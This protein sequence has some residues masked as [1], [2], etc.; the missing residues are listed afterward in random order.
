MRVENLITNILRGDLDR[1]NLLLKQLDGDYRSNPEIFNEKI[2]KILNERIDG[3][4]NIIHSA[5]YACAPTSNK[6]TDNLSS[7]TTSNTGGGGGGITMPIKSSFERSW[8]NKA[9]AA[10]TTIPPSVGTTGTIQITLSNDETNSSTINDHSYENRLMMDTSES[11]WPQLE[12]NTTIDPK[13]QQQLKDTVIWPMVKIDDKEKRLNSIK[14]LQALLD[15]ISLKDS[16]NELLSFKNAEGSTPFMYAINIR[17]YNAALCLLE[18]ALNIRK[19]TPN[20]FYKMIYPQNS[21]PDNCPLYVLCCNDTC[22]FTWTGDNHITQDIFECKTC[23]LV[24]NLCCCTECARTCHKGHD[25]KIKTSSP[26]A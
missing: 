9:S 6:D 25:C 3:N 26:T 22:S 18:T 11:Y 24:G 12:I 4:R 16:L 19:E 20:N 15:S 14:I 7:T 1:V 5:V 17:A 2:K 13:Q 8:S 10:T 23:T 21:N